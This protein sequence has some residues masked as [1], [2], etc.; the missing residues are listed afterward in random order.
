MKRMSQILYSLGLLTLLI[1]SSCGKDELAASS[2]SN[3]LTGG[4]CSCNSSEMPVCG[5]NPAGN[6]VTY[7]NICIA[8]CYQ[9]TNT[10]QGRCNCSESLVCLSDG[11]SLTECNAQAAIRNNR[12]LTIVKFYGCNSKPPASL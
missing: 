11:R 2:N 6:H 4:Q 8:S 1:L 12:S 7:P 3:P 9:A 5:I 10:V